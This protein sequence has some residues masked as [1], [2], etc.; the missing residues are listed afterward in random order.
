MQKTLDQIAELV[1]TLDGWCTVE[2]A[3]WLA[4]WIVAHRCVSIVEIG[5]FGGRSFIPMA[6]AMRAMDY[7]G[8]PWPGRCIGIDSYSNADCVASEDTPEGRQYWGSL[9]LPAI[10]AKAE[11]AIR[12]LGLKDICQLMITTGVN[13]L[14]TFADGTLDLV[15]V[16]GSHSEADSCKDVKLWWPKLR[17]GG[18]MVMDD[19]NWMSVRKARSIAAGLGKQVHQNEAWEAFQKVPANELVF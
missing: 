9:D 18:V 17:V 14:T 6:L 8:G 5:V 19:T 2:K 3:Q 4:T 15:H 11:E 10:R 1:P 7:Y 13:A 12:Q 16:D